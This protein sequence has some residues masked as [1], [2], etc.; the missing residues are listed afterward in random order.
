M[1]Y[2]HYWRTTEPMDPKQF[3]G[4][5]GDAQKILDASEALGIALGDGCGDGRPEVGSDALVFNGANIQ[6]IGA[7][8]TD[9]P[10]SIPWPAPS[11]SLVDFD[12]DPIAGKVAG[13]WFAGT[14]VSQRVAPIENGHGSGS[15]ETVAI[16]RQ[17]ETGIKF[18]CTKTAFRPYDLPTTAVLIA[19]KH[20]F[21]STLI[22]SDGDPKDWLDGMMLCFNTV[23]YGMDFRLN[24]LKAVRNPGSYVGPGDVS[25]DAK[26]LRIRAVLARAQERKEA[27]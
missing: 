1:G 14:L 19:L 4:F 3:A 6:P 26:A 12:P 27:M 22:T 24:T 11:A 7:W 17:T 18:N 23:G 8:T 9:E 25:Y 5:L 15:Y 16:E 10:V 21:P 20:H 13:S 2:S